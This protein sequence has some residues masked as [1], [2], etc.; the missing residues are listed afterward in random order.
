VICFH[1]TDGLKVRPTRSAN[2]LRR[3]SGRGGYPASPI[4]FEHGLLVVARPASYNGRPDVR[5]GV[6]IESDCLAL[7]VFRRAWV[8]EIWLL[9]GI[10][11]PHSDEESKNERESG[12]EVHGSNSGETTRLFLASTGI[13]RTLQDFS[14]RRFTTCDAAIRVSPPHGEGSCEF[15]ENRDSSALQAQSAI[16]V[17]LSGSFTTLSRRRRY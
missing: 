11:A 9:C 13:H 16:R 12:S 10:T 7:L 5:V 6:G 3:C 8:K 17:G 1:V 4:C 15:A 14:L 2:L